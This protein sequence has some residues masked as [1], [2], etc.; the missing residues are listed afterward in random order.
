MLAFSVISSSA[1][2]YII[3]VHNTAPQDGKQ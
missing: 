1:H 2:F 3:A